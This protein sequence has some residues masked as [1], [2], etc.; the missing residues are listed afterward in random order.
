MK[1]VS[2]KP[3]HLSAVHT[4]G[5]HTINGVVFRPGEGGLP[6]AYGLNENQVALFE[7]SAGF[8]KYH[9]DGTYIGPTGQADKLTVD[10]ATV[11][12]SA[13]AD[14]AK[15]HAQIEQWLRDGTVPPAVMQA[16]M[17]RAPVLSTAAPQPVNT[18]SVEIQGDVTVSAPSISAAPIIVPADAPQNGQAGDEPQNDGNPQGDEDQDEADGVLEM[19]NPEALAKLP[20]AELFALAKAFEVQYKANEPSLTIAQAIAEVFKSTDEY[21]AAQQGIIPQD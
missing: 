10:A 16:L 20:R 11:R 7:A 9:D 1:L 4:A 17:E 2:H 14:Q 12:L 18:A 5:S 19:D 13:A 21:K 15:A 8:S 6:T 3:A